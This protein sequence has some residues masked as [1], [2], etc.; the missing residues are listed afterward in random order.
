[1]NTQW[2]SPW[3]HA[4]GVIRSFGQQS[5]TLTIDHG[6][7]KGGIEM[8]A[9]TMRYDVSEGVDVSAFTENAEVAFMVK[10]GS[11]GSYR[12]MALCNIKTD[13]ANCLDDNIEQVKSHR[14]HSSRCYR[15]DFAA[16][17]AS[18]GAPLV[19]HHIDVAMSR[20]KHFYVRKAHRWIS[21]FVGVQLLM[22]TASGLYFSWTDIDEIHGDQFLSP[23][24]Q[25]L[26]FEL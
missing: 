19:L 1:M 13:G 21:V 24:L 15:Q 9:M 23:A 7:F 4:T 8:G 14:R 2:E 10:H 6:P 18:F 26:R 12:L 17:P 16:A 22:W 11:D 20:S 5:N 3:G 25:P